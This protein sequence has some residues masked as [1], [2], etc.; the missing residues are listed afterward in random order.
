MTFKKVN[1]YCLE[2]F[3]AHMK[4][5][6]CVNYID[7]YNDYKT[8]LFVFSSQNK[9]SQANSLLPMNQTVTVSYVFRINS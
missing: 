5:Y 3:L 4:C 6:M 8:H 7:S 1:R 2:Q 9:L